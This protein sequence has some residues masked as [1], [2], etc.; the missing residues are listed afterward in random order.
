MATKKPEPAEATLVQ[1]HEFTITKMKPGS[2]IEANFAEIEAKIAEITALYSGEVVSLDYLPQAKKDRAYLN[3]LVKSVDQRRIEAKK[4]YMQ[5][6][7]VFETRVK[8]LLAPVR[9]VSASIDVQIKAL[10]EQEKANKRRLLV[11]YY[12][13]MAGALVEAVT[14][15]QIEDPAWLNKTNHLEDCYKA[16]DAIIERIFRDEQALD[17]LALSHP[18]EAKAEFF[19]TLDLSR[20]IARSKALDDQEERARRI[21]AEKAANL[22]ALKP[23]PAPVKPPIIDAETVDHVCVGEPPVFPGDE[24]AQAVARPPKEQPENWVFECTC[25]RA[26]FAGIIAYLKEHHIEGVA[27]R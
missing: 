1:S 6:Y 5:P 8:T 23:E 2:S 10:E 17:G 11:D 25:T 7:D 9:D 13:G 19:A 27:R 15:E 24:P 4:A 16:I 12:E 21:E 20:A 18:L 26:E 14:F 22:A 3:G